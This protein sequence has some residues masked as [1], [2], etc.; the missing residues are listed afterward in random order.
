MSYNLNSIIGQNYGKYSLFEKIKANIAAA[1]EDHAGIT[2][3]F[4][5]L[6]ADGLT[7]GDI[8]GLEKEFQIDLDGNNKIQDVKGV[9]YN[10]TESEVTDKNVRSASASEIKDI[11]RAFKEAGKETFTRADLQQLASDGTIEGKKVDPDYQRAATALL[12][13]PEALDNLDRQGEFGDNNGLMDNT[14]WSQNFARASADASPSE[15]PTPTPTPSETPTPTPTPSETPTPTPTPENKNPNNVLSKVGEAMKREGLTTFHDSDL[16]ALAAGEGKFADA[17]AEEKAAAQAL[18]DND[19]LRLA[20]DVYGQD[21]GQKMDGA[22]DGGYWTASVASPESIDSVVG[23]YRTNFAGPGTSL[24]KDKDGETQVGG[25]NV[26]QALGRETEEQTQKRLARE[27]QLRT[28]LGVEGF[29]KEGFDKKMLQ[30]VADGKPINGKEVT[31]EQSA[32]AK[33]ILKDPS[34]LKV[35]DNLSSD[36]SIDAA[37]ADEWYNIAAIRNQMLYLLRHA[38]AE[39]ETQARLS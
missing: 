13:N 11:G 38:A 19:G 14:Y 18:L 12:N 37:N 21:G 22:Q 35:I 15:T 29:G 3:K 17:T 28:L 32:A 23:T 33:S 20:L 10:N 6:K 31:P 9:T 30:D 34:L 25:E 36:G 7:F 39:D 8:L 16:K 5:E 27:T 2:Q 4:N 1:E 26:E 24:D